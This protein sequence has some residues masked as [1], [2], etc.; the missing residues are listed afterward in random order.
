MFFRKRG[1]ELFGNPDINEADAMSEL[2]LE[3]NRT[4]IASG[5]SLLARLSGLCRLL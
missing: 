3:L 1:I 4:V 5:T 2:S